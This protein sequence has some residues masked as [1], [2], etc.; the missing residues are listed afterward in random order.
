M[1]WVRG[2]I[3]QGRVAQGMS[4]VSA[5]CHVINLV[6]CASFSPSVS[7]RFINSIGCSSY[8]IVFNSREIIRSGQVRL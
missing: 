2:I 4:T 5:E 7:F 6:Y 1:L 3:C 8:I